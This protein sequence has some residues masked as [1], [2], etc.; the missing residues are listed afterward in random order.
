MVILICDIMDNTTDD[1]ARVHA[2]R[3]LYNLLPVSARTVKD[4]VASVLRF[5]SGVVVPDDES[6][7][8][9]PVRKVMQV[10]SLLEVPVHRTSA[11]VDSLATPPAATHA[12]SPPKHAVAAGQSS[13]HH[14]P[15]TAR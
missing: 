8:T 3:T 9:E 12:A 10:L 7:H 6:R 1:L 14:A 15:A 13:N 2:T 5:G 4:A 11:Y